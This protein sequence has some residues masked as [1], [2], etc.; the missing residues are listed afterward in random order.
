MILLAEI[1]MLGGMMERNNLKPNRILDLNTNVVEAWKSARLKTF[2]TMIAYI[3]EN[4]HNLAF[5]DVEY[6]NILA[7]IRWAYIQGADE[8]NPIFNPDFLNEMYVLE[9]AS[10]NIFKARVSQI[11]SGNSKLQ[12]ETSLYLNAKEKLEKYFR[13]EIEKRAKIISNAREKIE[14]EISPSLQKLNELRNSAPSLEASMWI[15]KEYGDQHAQLLRRLDELTKIIEIAI[16]ELEALYNKSGDYIMHLKQM[17]AELMHY[18]W[19]HVNRVNEYYGSTP[20]RIIN[21]SYRLSFE[22]QWYRRSLLEYKK[23]YNP[24]WWRLLKFRGSFWYGYIKACYFTLSLKRWQKFYLEIR[25]SLY[26]LFNILRSNDKLNDIQSRVVDDIEIEYLVQKLL[27]EALNVS[28]GLSDS[29]NNLSTDYTW[30][31]PI[32]AEPE[33]HALRQRLEIVPYDNE[34]RWKLARCYF[35]KQVYDRA[36]QEYRVLLNHQPELHDAR[37]EL[38]DCYIKLAILDKALAELEYLKM[39]PRFVEKVQERTDIVKK[40][41][42]AQIMS[43]DWRIAPNHGDEYIA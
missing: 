23:R 30:S 5:L 26:V 14:N 27:Q 34:S 6:D 38:I 32:D 15:V 8:V 2:R 39:I 40:L 31:I 13:P 37:I 4:E 20:L 29:A 22:K 7:L 18:G 41:Q 19:N 42:V 16:L 36:L 9:E 28:K 33:I 43:L 11:K 10:I 25:Q 35:S 1:T 21:L 3:R 12:N 24:S 17:G